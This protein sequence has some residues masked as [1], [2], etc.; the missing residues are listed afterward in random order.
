[1]NLSEF[2]RRDEMEVLQKPIVL[3]FADDFALIKTRNTLIQVAK[4]VHM[5]SKRV[6]YHE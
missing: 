1:M 4:C 2:S 5:L 6:K 3:S